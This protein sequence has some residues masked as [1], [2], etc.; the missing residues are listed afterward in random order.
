M[1]KITK[2]RFNI[3]RKETF[4]KKL[5][6][7]VIFSIVLVGAVIVMKNI[8]SDLSERFMEAADEKMNASIELLEVK[9]TITEGFS[10]AVKKLP[11]IGEKKS[12]PV[13]GTLYRK[14]GLNKSDESSYYN[15]GIDI[16]ADSQSVKAITDGKVV[17]LGSN[18][19]LSGYIV[20]QNDDMTLI[21]GKIHE[22]FV[23]EGD[24][25][26]KGDL[27]G[28]LDEENMILHIEVWEDGASINP[29]S[30]FDLTK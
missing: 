28:A 24:S 12:T 7:Q 30:L 18:E 22:A 6:L 29:T 15:H 25:V 26:S 21:Y 23:S 11:F 13:I 2:K 3:K 14:Y 16:K 1:N 10:T 4:N 9:D 19:K 27:I 5:A 20:V 8:N 17:S